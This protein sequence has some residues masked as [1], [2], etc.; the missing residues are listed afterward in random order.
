MGFIYDNFLSYYFL[1]D[2]KHFTWLE[3]K[4]DTAPNIQLK[5]SEDS[6]TKEKLYSEIRWD[7]K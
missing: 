7:R 3:K 4:K 5:T 1:N 6:F 2:F